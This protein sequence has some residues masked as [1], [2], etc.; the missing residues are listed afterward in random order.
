MFQLGVRFANPFNATLATCSRSN[1]APIEL[2]GTP[3]VAGPAGGGGGGTGEVQLMHD[4]VYLTLIMLVSYLGGP[5]ADV[6]TEALCIHT[7]HTCKDCLQPPGHLD[8]IDDPGGD[9]SGNDLAAR[10]AARV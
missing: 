3:C 4:T 5:K 1:Q 6:H 10:G 2:P 8:R 7:P 9:R